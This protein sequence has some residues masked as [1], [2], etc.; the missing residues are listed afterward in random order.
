MDLRSGFSGLPA[1]IR[2]D[3]SRFALGFVLLILL[4]QV[5]IPLLMVIWTSLKVARPGE[6][7]F[8]DFSF[9]VANYVRAFGSGD[10]WHASWNT[11][12]FAL[13]STALAFGLGT[14]L[15]WVVHR[16]NTP[17]APLIGV[18]T[19]GRIIIP[20]ILITVSWIL[21]A[22]PSI[23]VLNHLLEAITGAKRTFNVYSFWGMVWVHSLE[24][25]PLAYLLL[26]AALQ[27][28]DPRLEEASLVAGAGQWS[29]FRRVSLPLILPAV[30]AAVMLLMIYTI[31]TF[32]VPLLLGGRAGVR[33]YTTEIYFNTARTPT[34]WGLSGAYSIAILM[35]CAGFLAAYFRLVR[36]GERY[37]TITGK[38]F[39][40]RR[41]DLGAWR[42]LT[43]ALGL[44][45]VFLI[46]GL[47]FLVMV[48]ASLLRRYQPPSLEILHSMSLENYYE[49]IR[50]P[51]YSSGPLWNSTL[52]GLG[53]ATAVML[54]VSAMSYFV[55]KTRLRARKLIDFLGFAPIAMPS[56]VLGAAFL[57]FYLLFPLPVLGT[58]TIIALAY[59]TR[60]MSVALRFVS[61]SMLQIHTELEEAA[62][63]AGGGWWK[64]FRAIYLPLLRPGLMAGWFWVMVHAYR[65]LTIALMLARSSNRTAAVVIY[66]LWENGSFPQLS[67][68]GVLIFALLIVLVLV[69]QSVGKRFGVREQV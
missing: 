47:P 11:L 51:A 32:E 38:D 33:V 45:L 8:F 12:C 44:L 50:D 46:T 9:S 10:F 36:H 65:E 26:S 17:L 40:P 66:D 18:I 62:A 63:V 58:L 31:E 14:F 56:V 60:Y 67:A 19:L 53:S 52:V 39:R 3:S 23:G 7:G 64:N 34:D 59:V 37:Q 2:L 1:R 43:C 21:L 22:S 13:A 69:G 55:H 48:Y 42:Y 5:A 24:I 49:I 6:P 30:G 61:T 54:L 68:F 27:S 57:W 25:T 16:T 41:I 28:M 15:A 29:T 4:Y 20:G 35:L